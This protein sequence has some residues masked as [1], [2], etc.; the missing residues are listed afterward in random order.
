MKTYSDEGKTKRI[1]NQEIC[2][3]RILLENFSE[4]IASERREVIQEGILGH[5][6]W[7]EGTEMMNTE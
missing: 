5:Q 3:E 1:R 4:G 2:S 6:E 7:S